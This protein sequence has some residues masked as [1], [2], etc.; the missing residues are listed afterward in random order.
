[1]VIYHEEGERGIIGLFFMVI[2]YSNIVQKYHYN[3]PPK[4][5]RAINPKSV[6]AENR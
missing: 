4:G 2:L 5:V 3:Y 6:V 1:M